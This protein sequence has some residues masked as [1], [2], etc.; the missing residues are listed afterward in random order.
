MGGGVS[1]S[2]SRAVAL[3]VVDQLLFI[4]TLRP[5]NS[6]NGFGFISCAETQSLFG[7]DVFVHKSIVENV[8]VGERVSFRVEMKRGQ[9]QA[10]DVSWPPKSIECDVSSRPSDACDKH[11]S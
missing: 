5:F 11:G 4:G 2:G 9:P 3:D 10:F 6:A 1:S 7:R 8:P